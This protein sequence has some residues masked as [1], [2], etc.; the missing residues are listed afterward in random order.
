M[1]YPTNLNSNRLLRLE[2]VMNFTGLSKSSIYSFIKNG[3]FPNPIKIGKRAVAW[4]SDE[5][6]DW[7]KSRPLAGLDKSHGEK[8]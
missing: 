3:L 2:V 6:Q 7:L 1:Q 5:L 4:R 8:P